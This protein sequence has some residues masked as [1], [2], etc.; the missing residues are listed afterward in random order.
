MTGT[1]VVMRSDERPRTRLP[2]LDARHCFS[3]GHHYDP[4]NTHHGLLL[5]SNDDVIAPGQG[6]GQHSHRDMEIVTWVLEGAL[7]HEDG[8]GNH[9]IITPGIA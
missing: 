6:F 1:V 7:E 2:W 5:V 9:G 8:M 3:F 4:A